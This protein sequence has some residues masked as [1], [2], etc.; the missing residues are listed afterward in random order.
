MTAIAIVC[1][2]GVCDEAKE[3][4]KSTTER[5]VV[6]SGWAV[7]GIC[8]GRRTGYKWF[9]ERAEAEAAKA[10]MERIELGGRKYFD[11]VEV[12]EEERRVE[13]EGLGV[14]RDKAGT[15]APKPLPSVLPD[16]S[17]EDG[18]RTS[19]RAPLE[20]TNWTG[21]ESGRELSFS[22]FA[23][24]QVRSTDRDR[25]C[26]GTWKM[27]SPNR[28]TIEFTQPSRILYV[29]QIEGDRICGLARNPASGNTWEWEA[30]RE[31]LHA[32]SLA[33]DGK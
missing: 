20:E 7:H 27:V 13:T 26:I 24:R 18:S 21:R 29:G 25:T 10:R 6:V 32:P 22:F 12:R 11:R 14:R 17:V 23:D 33:K 16:T 1:G 4:R 8:D 19:K 2:C 30:I 31:G 28:F 5:F 15:T 3:E 9:E